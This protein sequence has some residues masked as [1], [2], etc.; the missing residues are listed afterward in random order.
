[1]KNKECGIKLSNQMEEIKRLNGKLYEYEVI[2][3]QQNKEIS[4]LKEA[5]QFY[6]D[7]KQEFIEQI[8]MKDSELTEGERNKQGIVMLTKAIEKINREKLELAK[9]LESSAR[10]IESL[11]NHWKIQNEHIIKQKGELEKLAVSAKSKVALEKAEEQIGK[12]EQTIEYL[13]KE[14][15]NKTKQMESIRNK[16]IKELEEALRTEFE[17][18]IS[19]YDDKNRKIQNEISSVRQHSK[20]AAN[21]VLR[22]TNE[23]SQLNLAVTKL[24]AEKNKLNNELEKIKSQNSEMKSE[25]DSNIKAQQEMV[26]RLELIKSQENEA[27]FKDMVRSL[28]AEYERQL[29]E[30]RKAK[31]ESV[32]LLKNYQSKQKFSY[33]K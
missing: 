11:T 12:M 19:K 31:S 18:E 5:N 14:I 26:P 16:E 32:S 20:E 29:Q 10:D 15:Y 21:E 2:N 23:N 28:K 33:G 4:I 7:E 17:L 24:E 9:K 27:R 30:E 8:K 6:E 3:Q 1:M 22:I 13:Q 25:L